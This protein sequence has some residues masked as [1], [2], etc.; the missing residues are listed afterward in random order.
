[1]YPF[2]YFLFLKFW[3]VK[4]IQLLVS[5]MLKSCRKKFLQGIKDSGIHLQ[6]NF[7]LLQGLYFST[8]M[9][10]ES[11]IACALFDVIIAIRCPRSFYL[12]Q[13]KADIQG[14]ETY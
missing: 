12:C 14:N 13:I 1:M 3:G 9:R 5:S 4:N 2:V 7:A 10:L 6:L 8:S 11:E